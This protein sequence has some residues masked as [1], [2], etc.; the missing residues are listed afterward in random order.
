MSLLLIVSLVWAFSFGLIKGRLGGLD[1]AGVAV[2][3]LAFAT[4][5][6]LPLLRLRALPGLAALRFAAIGAMQFGAMYV[7]YLRAFAHL[8][9]HEVAL[10]TIFTPIYI[11]LFDAALDR[12]FRGTHFLA[13][14]LSVGGAALVMSGTALRPGLAVGFGLVQVSNVCFALGQIAYKRARATQPALRDRD[15][16]GL[17]YLGA[18]IATGAFSL[19]ATD[20]TTFHPSPAQW[21]VL[22]Y[23]GVLASGLCFFWWNLGALRVNNGTLAAFNNAKVP[24]GVAC[25][26]VFFGES[27]DLPR[28]AASLIL[29]MAAVLIA[30]R[31]PA[32]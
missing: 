27:A 29:L 31:K 6:F 17:L 21:G 23:L 25:S 1:P 10:F 32:A 12:R 13:A 2:V 5:V 8:Q 30:E 19:S 9:A 22:A 24:L 26:L 15:I 14:L 11:A 20:W 4:M 18:V 16:F 7:F 3:R 28:L